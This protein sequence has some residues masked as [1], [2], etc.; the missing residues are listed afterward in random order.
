MPTIRFFTA[1]WLSCVLTC[2][3][4]VLLA[5]TALYNNNSGQTFRTLSPAPD[6]SLT[7][8]TGSGWDGVNS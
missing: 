5:L 7:P 3:H 6:L 1:R 2:L 8:C 4:L